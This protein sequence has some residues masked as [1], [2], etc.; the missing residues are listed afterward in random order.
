MNFENPQ[1][2]KEQRNVLINTINL[3]N[4]DLEH[5]YYFTHQS[6]DRAV[7]NISKNG[8]EINNGLAGTVL[9]GSKESIQKQMQDIQ[10]GEG[11]Q[12]SNAMIVFAIP[13]SEVGSTV[14]QLDEI[15]DHYMEQGLFHIPSK[16]IFGTLIVDITQ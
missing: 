11:H 16:Y 7:N 13:K 14:R 15:S 1:N 6:D 8:F 2:K 4:M 3:E 12:G 5:Y 10:S 9:W